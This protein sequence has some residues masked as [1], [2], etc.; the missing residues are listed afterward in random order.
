MKANTIKNNGCKQMP[1]SDLMAFLI[2]LFTSF[3][4]ADIDRWPRNFQKK[5]LFFFYYFY[6]N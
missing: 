4:F 5:N 1:E 2:L 6:G 3:V